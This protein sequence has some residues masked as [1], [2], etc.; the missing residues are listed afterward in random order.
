MKSLF[1]RLRFSLAARLLLI[2]VGSLF[3]IVL[4]VSGF[5]AIGWGQHFEDTFR[6]H[7]Q[8]YQGYLLSELGEPPSREKARSLTEDLPLHIVIVDK[9]GVWSSDG[10]PFDTHS[11]RHAR[12]SHN[13]G[14]FHDDRTDRFFLRHQ[15]SGSEV[16]FGFLKTRDRGPFGL[17]LLLIAGILFGTYWLIKRLF[18]PL[19]PIRDG[20]GEFSD[21]NFSHRINAPRRDELGELAGQI[22][23]MADEI[24]AM[25]KAKRDLLLAISHELRSPLT[26]SKVALELIDQNEITDGIRRDINDMEQL[27]GEILESERLNSEHAHSVLQ[28]S[29][30]ELAGLVGSVTEK[31]D[32]NATLI[33]SEV[34]DSVCSLDRTRI[35]LLLTNLLGN[36]VRHN[37]QELGPVLLSAQR[38]SDKVEI[39]IRDH[40]EG[41]PPEHLPHLTEP[42]YRVDPSRQRKTGGYGLGLHLCQMIAK[43]HGGALQIDSRLNEGTTVTVTL[44]CQTE[45]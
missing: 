35:K 8:R 38:R 42:F 19:I 17:L 9:E 23:H 14:L 27:L 33:D 43:A 44:P 45:A 4:L 11:L 21:G 32:P 18:Q 26:R 13:P 5:F 40:G 15:A 12:R 7:L 31:L 10:K 41:I 29:D 20:V 3:C 28:R 1:A 24:D 36:A 25:L 30:C 2:S 22:N 16:Y 37:R 39:V 34:A 6:P